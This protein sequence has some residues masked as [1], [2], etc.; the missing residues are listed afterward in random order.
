M[1]N[2]FSEVI[3]KVRGD[4]SLPV[5]KRYRAHSVYVVSGV[6]VLFCLFG[7]G[8]WVVDNMA[9]N[10]KLG[11]LQENQVL[12]QKAHAEKLA[13]EYSFLDID[14]T[15]LKKQ[16]ND[17]VSWLS[18]GAVDLSMPIVQTTDNEFYLTHDIDKKK[19]V[20]GWAFVDTDV[21][22]ERQSYN[23]VLYGHNSVRSKMFGS[24]KGLLEMK[25]TATKEDKRIQF[26]TLNSQ[27][28]Y[29]IVSV[30][31][32]DYEDW[33]YV[34]TSF[35]NEGDKQAFVDRMKDRNESEVFDSAS[36]T[37]G[38][39]FLT[40]STCHGAIGTTKRLVVHAKLLAEK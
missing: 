26:T 29:E 27:R 9:M 11:L 21:N 34:K 19:N 20:M 33:N 25:E 6:I 36:V 15:D 32:T 40:F 37:T 18:I 14:F 3:V 12:G 22:M 5:W 1:R 13:D 2:W 7:I 23:T 16:N 30:Y 38:D 4:T 31:V 17:V 28:V 24:L 8:R 39:T 35:P 10:D